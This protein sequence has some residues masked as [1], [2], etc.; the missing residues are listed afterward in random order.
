MLMNAPG[1]SDPENEKPSAPAMFDRQP[2]EANVDTEDQEVIEINDHA[3]FNT[4]KM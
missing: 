4:V 2:V 1:G 3:R